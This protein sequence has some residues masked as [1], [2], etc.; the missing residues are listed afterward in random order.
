M[1]YDLAKNMHKLLAKQYWQIIW[2]LCDYFGTE[3]SKINKQPPPTG[4]HL[5]PH[6]DLGDGLSQLQKCA[7]I[8]EIRT[9]TLKM[10][11]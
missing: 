10:A 11:N 5:K 4:L 8:A 3:Q 2:F 1:R 6:N 7:D 9:E